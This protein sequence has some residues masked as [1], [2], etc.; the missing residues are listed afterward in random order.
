MCASI[1]GSGAAGG[2]GGG[3]AA[4]GAKLVPGFDLV[5]EKLSLADRIARADLVVTGE[6]YL[7]K[8]SFA[9]KAVGGVAHLADQAGRPGR[10]DRRRRRGRQSHPLRVP[11]RAVWS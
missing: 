1:K 11:G 10:G 8:Q 7:D 5:A 6:G 3:L 4:I 2:L 9:G